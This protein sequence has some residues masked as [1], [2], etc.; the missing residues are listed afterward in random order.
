[1]KTNKGFTLIEL[2]VV[3]AIIAILAAILFPVFARAR[4]KARQTNCM[5]NQRQIALSV[6]MYV[7]DHNSMFM[8]NP[9]SQTWVSS[10][11][12][13]DNAL[14]NCPSNTNVG[15]AGNPDYGFNASLL[16]VSLSDVTNPSGMLMLAD[17]VVDGTKPNGLITNVETDLDARHSNSSTFACVDGHVVSMSMK[18]AKSKFVA[19]YKGGIEIF[20]Q[21]TQIGYIYMGTGGNP[22]EYRTAGD[23]GWSVINPLQDLP[24]NLVYTGSDIPTFSVTYEIKAHWSGSWGHQ[25]GYRMLGLYLPT[26]G[27]NGSNGIYSGWQEPTING[28]ARAI[29]GT[30]NTA[31]GP[32]GDA[33]IK[34]DFPGSEYLNVKM[35]CANW[36]VTTIL[37]DAKK[38]V[39]AVH[40]SVINDPSIYAGRTKWSP[41]TGSSSG[42]ATAVRNLTFYQVRM[43]QQ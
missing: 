20:L 24:E 17:R 42:N 34:W 27:A 1:M 11:A 9:G 19:L 36:M 31:V 26:T 37:M 33:A 38:T 28:F 18:N 8:P 40:S 3:I 13:S 12:A 30:A 2:L 6:T 41:M 23:S 35:Y 10:L 14:Y 4:E 21:G 7:Q 32:D 15:I 43:V 39:I 5:N 25:A 16:G 22:N 29:A